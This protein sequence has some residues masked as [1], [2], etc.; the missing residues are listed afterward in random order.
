M[1]FNDK[2]DYLFSEKKSHPF[3]EL[4]AIERCEG[5]IEKQTIQH[6]HGYLSENITHEEWRANQDMG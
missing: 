4:I 6:W 2:A 1:P 3:K 5:E